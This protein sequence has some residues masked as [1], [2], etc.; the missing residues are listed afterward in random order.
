MTHPKQ[1]CAEDVEHL[2]RNAQLRDEL[3]PLYDE[4]IGR[5]NA[6]VMPTP[7]ENEF[8]ESMLA[9]ERA[10][11][12]PISQWFQPE[13]RLPRPET[14]SPQQLH[15]LLWETIHRLFELRIVLDFTDHLS[16]YELYCLIYR[17][18][19]P[20]HEK[21][22]DRSTNYLHWD[23]AG[24]DRDPETWLRYYASDR[25]RRDWASELDRPLPPHERPPYPRHLPKAPL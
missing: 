9:W 22:I 17:D 19:L 3:E 12:L 21:K 16:D 5:V 25:E 24:T 15:D 14:L 1:P 10:P 23:C 4:S 11:M 20:T 13:L 8:L 18:I 7:V 6:E 2:L